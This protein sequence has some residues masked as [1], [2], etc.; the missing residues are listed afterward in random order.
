MNAIA[1]EPE[2]CGG[3]RDADRQA[4]GRDAEAVREYEAV[5][6]TVF[7]ASGLPK[8]T[9]RALA[10]PYPTDTGSLTV[11][12]LVQRLQVSPASIS[13][14]VTFLE[15]QGL[16][17]RERDERRRERYVVDGLWCQAVI[18]GACATA[19]LG[20]TVWQGVAVL[21]PETPAAARLEN[22]RPLRGGR[23]VDPGGAGPAD[24]GRE[25]APPDAA[26]P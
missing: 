3:E 16:I 12:G 21:D 15:S 9:S 19:H 20:E 18:A 24:G 17:R 5:F 7:M 8:M 2:E 1:E 11:P 26:G 13:K 10:C 22:I 6:A 25:Q 4:H 23:R 14:A